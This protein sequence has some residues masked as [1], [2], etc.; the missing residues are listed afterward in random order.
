MQ[1]PLRLAAAAAVLGLVAG[2]TGVAP[3]DS[4]VTVRLSDT[5]VLADEPVSIT[6]DGLAPGTD[7]TVWTRLH[8]ALGR[9]WLAHATFT[10]DGSG[11]VDVDTAIPTAGTYTGADPLGLFWSMRPADGPDPGWSVPAAP[12]TPVTVVAQVGGTAVAQ[13]DLQRRT[14]APGVVELPVREAGL[15]GVLYLPPGAG[16][17]PGAVL[18]SGSD[19]GI[20]DYGVAALLASRG[21]A[22]LA[23]AYFGTDGVPSLLSRIP[24]EYFGGAFDWLTARPEV[25][26]GQVGV[27]GL[28]RGAEL[29]LLLGA[30][31]PKVGAVVS[32][33][34]SGYG[35]PGL[36]LTG[37]PGSAWTHAGR[38][39]P[40]LDA[41]F[42]AW[43]FLLP[44][45][46]GG[47]VAGLGGSW[48]GIV[49]ADPAARAA[50]E[51]PVE[52]IDG[53]VL[54]LSGT[55]DRLW[56][57]PQLS[58]VALRRLESAG[59]DHPH[60]HVS[61]PGAGHFFIAAPG[62]P[63]FVDATGPY[64]SAAGGGSPQANAAAAAA[65]WPLVLET[66][67]TGLVDR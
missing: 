23:L 36:A 57:S 65:S 37:T 17:H 51:I 55:D 22:T 24:L 38:D 19:G 50:T 49:A 26:D 20:P 31:F 12:T 45:L 29:A 11:L 18:L 53:P 2:C 59:H 47:P 41:A 40:Y 61:Y 15:T 64:G 66:L 28:S 8:D 7:V 63:A 5:D 44:A 1:I 54:L 58:D 33:V 14:V 42:D 32:Y 6:V 16:P 60:R 10:A 21:Y 67:R 39:V 52:R 9:P 35:Y 62:A 3:G 43:G 13:A 27:L 30:T 25:A 34:G 56:P 48:P 4:P 46:V